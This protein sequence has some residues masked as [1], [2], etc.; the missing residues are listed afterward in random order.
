[1][2]CPAVLRH[3]QR[4]LDTE[5]GG[6]IEVSADDGCSKLVLVSEGSQFELRRATE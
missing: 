3:F 4:W 6:P 1:L 2:T 5:S